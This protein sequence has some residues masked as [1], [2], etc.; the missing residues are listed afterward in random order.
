MTECERGTQRK[1]ERLIEHFA[2]ISLLS[3][4]SFGLNFNWGI[5]FFTVAIQGVSVMLFTLDYMRLREWTRQ[6]HGV[7]LGIP[8]FWQF[9]IYD[10]IAAYSFRYQ[11]EIDRRVLV[12][13][14][15]I[16]C[17]SNSL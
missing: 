4:V 2:S 5:C 10:R 6:K 1:S 17:V 15:S 7:T 14:G 11:A 16:I 12:A 8:D 9:Q 13:P 3:A